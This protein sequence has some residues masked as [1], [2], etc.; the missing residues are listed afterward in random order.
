M[1]YLL[2]YLVSIFRSAYKVRGQLELPS[3]AHERSKP[4]SIED[5]LK[6]LNSRLEDKDE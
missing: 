1:K 2:L 6:D 5:F 3:Q 4:R